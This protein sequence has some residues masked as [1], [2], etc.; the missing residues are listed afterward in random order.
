MAHQPLAAIS[1]E[2]VGVAAEQT[3][4]FGFNGLCQ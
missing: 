2:L 1:D 4:D 3:R